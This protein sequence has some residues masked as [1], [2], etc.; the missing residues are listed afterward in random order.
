M[1]LY[2]DDPEGTPS[3]NIFR[4]TYQRVGEVLDLYY[5]GG[6][7]TALYNE[8]KARE[9]AEKMAKKIAAAEEQAR[10]DLIAA[11]GGG[12]MDSI[13]LGGILELTEGAGGI[14]PLVLVAGIVFFVVMKR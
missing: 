6:R 7:I 9:E 10:L 11:G 2:K 1:I 5:T 14:L 4:K 8:Q 12:L 3:R 13:G